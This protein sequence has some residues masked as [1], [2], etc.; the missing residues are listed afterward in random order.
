MKKICYLVIFGIVTL[1]GCATKRY[2]SKLNQFLGTDMDRLISVWGI[3]Q[4]KYSLSNGGQVFEYIKRRNVTVGGDV[5]YQAVTT[6]NSETAYNWNLL[7]GSSMYNSESTKMVPTTTPV[8]NLTLTCLTRFS[9]NKNN[10]VT[11]VAS[12]GNACY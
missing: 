6:R 7:P 9:I 1:T 3:P 2:E 11:S 4:N 5:V 12:E 8:R 10:I